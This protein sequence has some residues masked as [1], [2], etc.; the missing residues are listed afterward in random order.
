MKYETDSLSCILLEFTDEGLP[1][2]TPRPASEAEL[3]LRH[4]ARKR[5]GDPSQSQTHDDKRN[6]DGDTQRS[7]GC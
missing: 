1:R 7:D 3:R 4:E 6:D 5:F 2:M